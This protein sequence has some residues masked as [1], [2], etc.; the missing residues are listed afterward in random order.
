MIPVLK[1]RLEEILNKYSEIESKLLDID[2]NIDIRLS[3]TKEH[4]DLSPVIIA[5]N[6][7]Q[8]CETEIEG[9]KEILD[10][11]DID[12]SLREEALK[13]L[14]SLKKS[15]Q[16]CTEI[17]QKLLIPKDPDDNRNAIIEIRA[18]TGGG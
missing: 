15:L 14:D 1:N 11:K 13:E 12:S 9:V 7:L 3:L 4:S 18:G 8:S 16:K 17:T 5:I 10:D 2:I 6:E